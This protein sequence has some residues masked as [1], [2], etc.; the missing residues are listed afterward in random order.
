MAENHDLRS[1]SVS[2]NGIA[3]LLI[4]NVLYLLFIAKVIGRERSR[5]AMELES[6]LIKR[7]ISLYI[8]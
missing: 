6:G 5:L 1:A 2:F 7:E 4:V 3:D 8:K